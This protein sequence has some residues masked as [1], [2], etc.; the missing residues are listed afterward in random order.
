MASNCSIAETPQPNKRCW[1]GPGGGK[2]RT[3]SLK[4]PRPALPAMGDPRVISAAVHGTVDDS[5]RMLRT[6]GHA[7]DMR[8]GQATKAT[9]TVL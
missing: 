9:Y 5:R 2:W 6:K 7:I 8:N 1:A 4:A 3:V